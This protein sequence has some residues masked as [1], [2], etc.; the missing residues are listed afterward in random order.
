LDRLLTHDLKRV[1]VE[2]ATVRVPFAFHAR[3]VSCYDNTYEKVSNLTD[4]T[5][6][7]GR[8]F[9]IGIVTAPPGPA[10]TLLPQPPTSIN[11]SM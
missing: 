4:L 6:T 5:S 7:W 11:I 3:I 2:R 10:M 9:E 1:V 8:P